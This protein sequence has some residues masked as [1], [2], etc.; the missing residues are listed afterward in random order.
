MALSGTAHAEPN[1]NTA[2]HN[3]QAAC[4]AKVIVAFDFGSC[5]CRI[6]AGSLAVLQ[7]VAGDMTATWT[8]NFT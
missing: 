7:I 5:L 6:F 1:F 3:L 4:S 2:V 8:I